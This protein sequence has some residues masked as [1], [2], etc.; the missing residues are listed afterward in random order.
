MVFERW[1]HDCDQMTP[2]VEV[3]VLGGRPNPVRTRLWRRIRGAFE[4]YIREVL[5]SGAW[6]MRAIG[7]QRRFRAGARNM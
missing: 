1:T 5:G 7:E 4:S 2:Y 6:Y 3:D